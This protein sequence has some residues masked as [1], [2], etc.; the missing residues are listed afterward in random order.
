M[1]FTSQLP[2]P[3]PEAEKSAGLSQ[4]SSDRNKGFGFSM[5]GGNAGFQ[6]N[7]TKSAGK[8]TFIQLLLHSGGK[9][10]PW[11]PSGDQKGAGDS[12]SSRKKK[13]RPA[14]PGRGEVVALS[15]SPREKQEKYSHKDVITKRGDR[16]QD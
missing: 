6:R 14:R 12:G 11:S 16:G 9:R 5:V 3:A 4:K 2:V 15:S 10:E 13:N 8:K 7:A 1:V